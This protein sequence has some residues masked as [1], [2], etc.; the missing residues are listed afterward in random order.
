M[1]MTLKGHKGFTLIELLIVVAIIGILAAI[2]VPAYIGMQEKSRKSNIEKAAKSAQKDIQHW[3]NS[4]LKGS[5]ATNM[6]AGFAEVDTNWDGSIT[7][8]D[9][10]NTALFA[11]GGALADTAVST[12]Y[13]IARSGAAFGA[14]VSPWA[15]MD[16]CAAGAPLF[17]SAA[18]PPVAPANPCT[19]TL[20]P[21]VGSPGNRVTI[22]A[23][24]NGPGGSNTAVAEQLSQQTVT[25][26]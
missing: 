19:V 17:T 9:M 5:V 15:G 8:A 12:Q 16:A 14:E 25:A 7:A 18:L 24:S 11:V 10:V 23:H 20:S 6:G 22:S 21:A 26:E 13:A 4:A 3:L 2:A 1:N